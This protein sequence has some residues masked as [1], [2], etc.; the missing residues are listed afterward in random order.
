MQLSLGQIAVRHGCRLRGDPDIVVDHVATLATAGAGAL[1]FLANP[2]YRPQLGTTR[3]GAVILTEEAVADC[4]VACLVSPDPHLSYARIAADL[5][6]PAPLTPGVSPAAHVASGCRIG[7]GS[8][9]SAGA[10][11]GDDVVL[12]ARVFIGPNAVLGAGCAVGDDSRVMAAVVLYPRVRI[13]AR[14][15]VHSGAVLGADGFGY[16]RD[17]DGSRI[18]IPQVGGVVVG[19]DVEIGANTTIDRGAIG[20]T[21]IG[22]GVRLD[23]QIQV[24]HNVIIGA[25]T[26]IAAQSGISGSTRIG[27]RCV[28]GGDVAVAGHIEV[29]DDVM[30]GGGT[31]VT[32]SIRR[33]GI[34]GGVIPADEMT[35]WRRNAVRFG[36]L[37]EIARRVRELEKAMKTR[38]GEKS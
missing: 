14:C 20:D 2:R 10:V 4:P 22:D 24:A 5:H 35:R 3:A 1:S 37:D 15:I 30:I 19:D 26:A 6:P 28:I 11:L 21:I 25:H 12:G 38:L 18:K 33:P 34:Y 27:A 17:V 23:N 29:A 7:E 13:G 32:G 31:R 16:A 9:I 8:E 36:Q